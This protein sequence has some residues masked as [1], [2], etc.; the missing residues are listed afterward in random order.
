MLGFSLIAG[1]TAAGAPAVAGPT[2]DGVRAKGFVRCGVSE[3][4]PGF[5]SP[6]AKGHW[7]GIDVDF[8]RAVA[9]AILGDPMKVKF[10]PLTA[11]QRFTALQ[12]GELDLLSRNTTWTLTRDTRL[13]LNFAGVTY[14]DGQGFMVRKD[15]GV[16]SAAELDGA[17]LCINSG[18]TTELNAAD[19]FRS[20]GMK[21]TPVTFEKSDEVVAAYD[22]SNGVELWTHEWDEQFQETMGGD[23]PRAT[24]TWDDGRL[25]AL[26]AGGELRSLTADTGRLLWRTNILEDAGAGNLA[27]AMSASPLVVDN[28]VIVLPGGRAGR[29]V[30]AYDADTGDTLWTTLD[31]VAGYTAPMLV[32]LAG[33]RQILVVT[34]A[35]AAG[36]RV[37]DGTLL[38]DYP[39]VVSN[40]PNMA[41]PIVVGPNRLFISASYGQGSAMVE[42]TGTGDGLAAREVW[43]TNRMKNKFSSSV[44]HEGFIYGL[45]DNIL[46]C[47]DAETG[48]LVWKGGRYGYGQLLFAAGHL[49]VL[50][51]RGEIALVRA[52]PDGHEEVDR[53]TAID[54]KTWN[55]PTIADGTLFVRNTTEMAAF[56]IRP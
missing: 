56:D 36:L 42:V 48:E 50:T 28:M 25:F 19:Y 34:A 55:V 31:D 51:E 17:T 6:D 53:F 5:S 35:R 12:S 43:R 13:G 47:M 11:K 26:G 22:P 30:V 15:L 8:C 40:V 52:T 44:L 46:A 49:V 39:W 29:S 32:E 16:K 21:Y 9:A 14:Y 24:P 10:V 45:D 54:G 33:V 41:Q 37:D 2:L 1:L 7:K 20:N 18:T 27:W 3:G 23:G 38:W 4:L